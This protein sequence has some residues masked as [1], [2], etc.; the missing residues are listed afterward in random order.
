MKSL[1]VKMTFVI[2]LVVLA[3]TGLLLFSYQRASNSMSAQLEENYSIVADKY[4]QE[5]TAW[6]NANATIIDT[7]AAEITVG[8]I[9][10]DDYEAF[11]N[12]LALNYDLLNQNGYI[13]DIYF[14][15]PDNR[16]ACASDYIADGTINY[17]EREW[18]TEAAG[19]GEVFFS[20][21]Y[22]DS[23]TG[24]PIITISKAVYR[25]NTLQ[26]VLVIAAVA[27]VGLLAGKLGKKPVMITGLIIYAVSYLLIILLPISWPTII[28]HV[29]FFKNPIQSGFVAYIQLNKFIVGR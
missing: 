10:E 15:Y 5:I 6:I 1:H 26:G 29:I 28:I 24:K 25:D 3:A 12:Y 16:M 7:M 4:A 20:T 17:L 22:R 14:T 23:D 19:T 18:F 27:G 2:L 11:H 21:P 13:Y 9:Y 8:A